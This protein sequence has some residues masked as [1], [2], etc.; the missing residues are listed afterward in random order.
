MH[1]SQ[2]CSAISDVLRKKIGSDTQFIRKTLRKN[3]GVC[4]D[5]HFVLPADSALGPVV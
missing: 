3:N 5:V 4:P 1:Y 2:F